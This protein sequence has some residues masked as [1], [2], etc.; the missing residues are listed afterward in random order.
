MTLVEIETK[1]KVANQR[2]RDLERNQA[3]LVSRLTGT[4]AE[5]SA[6]NEQL[7]VMRSELK[8][9]QRKKATSLP[10]PDVDE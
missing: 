4:Q 6:A 10:E 1:L 3:S 9:R 8:S 2:I 5:L 7:E